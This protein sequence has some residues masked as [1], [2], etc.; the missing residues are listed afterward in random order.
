MGPGSVAPGHHLFLVG[1]EDVEEEV[2]RLAVLLPI[3]VTVSAMI[4]LT[5]AIKV[6]K[7]PAQGTQ[8]KFQNPL[9]NMNMVIVI[10]ILFLTFLQVMSYYIK[11]IPLLIF[12]REPQGLDMVVMMAIFLF[13]NKQARQH[14]RRKVGLNISFTSVIAPQVGNISSEPPEPLA[15]EMSEVP[16][17]R[18]GKV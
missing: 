13:S 15:L 10:V 8:G 5:I 11:P 17:N 6:K 3:A 9:K 16:E 14:A 7:P 18:N 1:R 2:P 4:I 12:P